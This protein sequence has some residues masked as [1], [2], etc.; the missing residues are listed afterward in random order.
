MWSLFLAC[1]RPPS[2]TPPQQDVVLP[3]L[4]INDF[5]GGLYEAAVKGDPDRRYGGLGWLAAAVDEARAADPHLLLLDGGD[6]FQGS[7]PVNA[8]HG[9]AAVQALELLGVDAAAIGNHEFD[10]G[11]GASLRGALEAAAAQ[12]DYPYLSANI[13]HADGSPWQPPNI[14]PWTVL[15]RAGLRVGVV[16]L[17]TA[18]TPTVTNPKNVA[19]LTFMDPVDTVRELLPELHAADLDVTVLVGHLTGGCEPTSYV[20]ND[21]PCTPDGEIGRLLTEL[22]EGTFD[23]MVLGHE[24]TVLHHRVGSTF[25]LES[26]TGGHLLGRVDLVVG[27]DGVDVEGS[28]I[29]PPR[30]I[31]HPPAEPGCDGGQRPTELPVGLPPWAPVLRE[32]AGAAALISSL[33]DE[34]GSLCQPVGC[35][36]RSLFRRHDG[37]SELGDWLADGLRAAFPD[38]D[39]AVQNSGGIRADLPAGTIRRETL[40]RISPFDNRA[41]LVAMTGAQVELMLQLGTRGAH[42]ALQVSGAAYAFDPGRA[43]NQLCAATVGG[44]PVD[45]ERTYRVVVSDFLAN[46]GDGLG[47]AFVGAEVLDEGP[48][49]REVFY[50]HAARGPGCVGDAPLV[51]PERPR[52]TVGPCP[53]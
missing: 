52:I 50:S 26:R 39:F 2:V 7:W 48:L 47:P 29:A 30:P 27:P 45:P 34:V 10:Y 21:D 35:A 19:D 9:R 28:R 44:R 11:G 20:R 38:V 15:E 24:H 5:H 16:G 40:Q 17:T 12:A 1:H 23:V 36:T 33:E 13:R 6:A 14:Q 25:L 32:S 46:G 18:T 3:I 42:G 49:T 51:D 4:A 37:E 53:R 22:P 8:T 43:D 31:A 41:L